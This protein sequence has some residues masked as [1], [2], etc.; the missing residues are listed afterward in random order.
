MITLD[1]LFIKN[2]GFQ[3]LI[4]TVKIFSLSPRKNWQSSISIPYRYCENKTHCCSLWFYFC[5]SIP[6]RYCENYRTV[7]T[8][9]GAELRISIP[10]RYCEN[11]PLSFQGEQNTC[12]SIPYR[13]CEN[14]FHLQFQNN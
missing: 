7:S 8:S 5:I 1:S 10:Y 12:I 13:Y 6:Y 4:G 9:Y 14:V 2:C 11:R 3:F